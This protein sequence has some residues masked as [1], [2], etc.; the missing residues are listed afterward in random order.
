MKS[1][2]RFPAYPTFSII[3]LK[4]EKLN[5]GKSGRNGRAATAKGSCSSIEH[6]YFKVDYHTVLS[7][8]IFGCK[9]NLFC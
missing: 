1:R 7:C 6:I 8:F 9:S 3:T 2:H 5:I 4:R